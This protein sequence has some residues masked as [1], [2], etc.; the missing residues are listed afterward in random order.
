MQEY[1]LTHPRSDGTAAVFGVRST[2]KLVHFGSI[3]A[4]DGRAVVDLRAVDAPGVAAM[5]L[6]AELVSGGLAVR[7]AFCGPATG[8][9]KN[10]PQAPARTATAR[11]SLG[12]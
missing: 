3:S 4:R 6:R 1:V 9:R 12:G 5:K 7:E 11:P 8:A 10:R 2:G